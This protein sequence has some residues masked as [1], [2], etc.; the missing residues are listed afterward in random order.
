MVAEVSFLSKDG[1][2]IR[3]AIEGR[4][5]KVLG[6]DFISGGSKDFLGTAKSG[7]R[8]TVKA[9]RDTDPKK[10]IASMR[11]AI[12]PLIGTSPAVLPASYVSGLIVFEWESGTTSSE[13]VIL[14]NLREKLEATEI[15]KGLLSRTLRL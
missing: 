7:F 10:L 6:K 3:L 4:S 1:L 15:G 2:W 14:N 13:E 8:L 5:S 11:D 12:V 9:R